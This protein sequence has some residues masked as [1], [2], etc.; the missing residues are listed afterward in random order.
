MEPEGKYSI[1]LFK[2]GGEGAGLD[3]VLHRQD[4]LSVAHAIYRAC[5]E[6]VSGPAR[7]AVIPRQLNDKAFGN[8]PAKAPWETWAAR[9]PVNY[10]AHARSENAPSAFAAL[11]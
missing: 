3:K 5:V 7:I 8:V 2:P 10:P 11:A 9:V 4:N 6:Q 1:E